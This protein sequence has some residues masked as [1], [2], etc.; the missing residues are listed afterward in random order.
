[1]PEPLTFKIITDADDSGIKKYEKGLDGLNI[2]SKRTSSAINQFSSEL[3]KA[4]SGADV[5]SAGA[6][7]L[8]HIFHQGLFGA[9]VIGGAKLLS[10]Q[11]KSMA[12]M[13]RGVGEE[14]SAAVKQL[15]RMGEPGNLQD[16]VKG[17]DMLDQKLDSV[18][19][20]LG[21]IK[22]GNWFSKILAQVTGTTDELKAQEATLTKIRDSQIA[23][24]FA[25]EVQNAQSLQGLTTYQK[26]LEENNIKL[27]E[28]L[29]IAERITDENLKQQARENAYQLSIIE[30]F[31]A[32]E[33]FA[34]QREDAEKQFQDL[35]EKRIDLQYELSQ[36]IQNEVIQQGAIATRASGVGG[37]SRGAG[38][39]ASSFENQLKKDAERAYQDEKNRQGEKYDKLL[40]E[41]LKAQGK[42]ND[43][44]AVQN[45]KI[46]RAEEAAREKAKKEFEDP[47]L[48]QIEKV[49]QALVNNEE[50]VIRQGNS[51]RSL[52][53]S[54]KNAESQINKMASSIGNFANVLKKLPNFGN[55]EAKLMNYGSSAFDNNGT[56]EEIRLLLKDNLEQMRTYTFVK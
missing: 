1:M 8:A 9:V 37:T 33:K 51:I 38:Q 15:Q 7:S 23:F 4:K 31:N 19:K 2:S 47:Y 17:A 43:A 16:A 25:I 53:G 10:D 44:N 39:R 46:K 12:E 22:E 50:Q 40:A 18:S 29:V 48:K 27:K 5:A 34:K 21:E 3:L 49:T 52:G 14:T 55:N 13:I 45:E 30:A 42:S 56:L 28:R 24:G 41:E 36:A 11:I 6:E 32:E 20:K 54:A 26:S 35:L